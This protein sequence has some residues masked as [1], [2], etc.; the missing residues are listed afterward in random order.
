MTRYIVRMETVHRAGEV[1]VRN[2]KVIV[3]VL[4]HL[5]ICATSIVSGIAG[6]VSQ[7]FVPVRNH[8][9]SDAYI[10]GKRTRSVTM[11]VNIA[12]ARVSLDVR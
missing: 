6:C 5:Y 8:T 10:E 7:C 1:V 3:R 2:F 4:L 9:T 11:N 12:C